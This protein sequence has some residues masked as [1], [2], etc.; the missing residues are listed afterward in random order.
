MPEYQR[1]D[2][3]LVRGY[4]E[5][6]AVLRVLKVKRRGLT[7]CSESHY[8]PGEPEDGDEMGVGYPWRDIVGPAT[9]PA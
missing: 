5:R 1:G 7:L 6:E 8:Q 3:V 4:Q 2:R 9:D